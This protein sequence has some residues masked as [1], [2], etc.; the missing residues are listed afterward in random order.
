M[1]R[2]SVVVTL[3][4]VV[5]VIVIVVEHIEQRKRNQMKKIKIKPTTTT[6]EQNKSFVWLMCVCARS[7]RSTPF[8]H[9]ND[10]MMCVCN[11]H[12]TIFRLYIS[13]LPSFSR[14]LTKYVLN[15]KLNRVLF[16]CIRDLM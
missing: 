16:R 5:V 2:I 7:R 10:V 1:E 6:K 15:Q 4:I 11:D 12:G 13:H 9:N 3:S 14:S 8:H